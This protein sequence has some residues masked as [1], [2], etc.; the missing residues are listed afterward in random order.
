M[1]GFDHVAPGTAGALG[2][3]VD[4]LR[5][6][7]ERGAPH[8]P[9]VTAP[10]APRAAAPVTAE[11]LRGDALPADARSASAAPLPHDPLTPVLD[12]LRRASS[13]N[14][15]S[16][17]P[18]LPH[19]PVER[20][21]RDDAYALL[22]RHFG[23]HERQLRQHAHLTERILDQLERGE[24]ATALPA[25]AP[26]QQEVRLLCPAGGRSGGRFLLRN[27]LGRPVVVA[28]RASVLREAAEVE[29]L[30]VTCTP[31]RAT[32]EP[33]EE[34]LA[35][36]EVDLGAALPIAHAPLELVIDALVDERIVQKIWVV[37]DV[38]AARATEDAP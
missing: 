3:L 5:A 9:G 6:L 4:G 20:G 8:G 7:H 10:A 26:L 2:A 32:L 30:A 15:A 28:L 17:A 29:G 13:A 11:V 16:A 1:K 21:A 38:H 33:E 12:L 14:A 35:R 36:V 27:E 23:E 18:L 24:V 31:R 37:V 34:L 25:A 19:A 22:Q